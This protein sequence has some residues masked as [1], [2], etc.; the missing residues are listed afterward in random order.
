M[1]PITTW[2]WPSGG[3]SGPT[4]NGYVKI[5]STKWQAFAAM[6]AD[7][8]IT[9]WGDSTDGGSGAPTDNGYVNIFS[10]QRAFAAMK[11]DGSITLLGEI[12]TM[13]VLVPLLLMA[14]SIYSLMKEHLLH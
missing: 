14:M 6:K 11:A 4:D 13:V 9:A 1:A 3:G 8:S 12:R 2:G 10:T 7:G 5:F